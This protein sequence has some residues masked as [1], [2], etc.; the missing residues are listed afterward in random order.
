LASSWLASAAA[1]SGLGG[2]ELITLCS[3]SAVLA[4]KLVTAA[5][6]TGA[7]SSITIFGEG[8]STFWPSSAMIPENLYAKFKNNMRFDALEATCLEK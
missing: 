7:A 8:S 3:S 1:A 4:S 2:S 5:S 6:E